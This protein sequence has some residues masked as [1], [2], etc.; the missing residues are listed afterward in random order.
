MTDWQFFARLRHLIHHDPMG[1]GLDRIAGRSLISATAPDLEAACRSLAQPRQLQVAIVTGFYVP[2][3]ECYETD[4][5]LGAI[6]LAETLHRLGAG[7]TIIA[8]PGCNAVH[9]VALR[10]NGLEDHVLL[11]DLPTPDSMHLESWVHRFW[12]QHPHLTHLVA[13]ERAG[14]SHHLQSL[15]HQY[16]ETP[17]PLGSF[18]R[19]VDA[20]SW[21][22]PHNM[23][24]H[25][26]GAFTSGAHR[27]FETLPAQVKSVG[28]GDGGNEIGMGRVPWDVVRNNIHLG[29]KIACRV[30][31][32]QLIVAGTSN[33]GAYALAAGV[34]WL[35]Q[36]YE[37]AGQF[38]ADREAQLWEATL[39]KEPLVDGVTAA[40]QLTVDG[41]EWKEYR[42]PMDAMQQLLNQQRSV[43]HGVQ[44]F[45]SVHG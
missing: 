17:A 19:E 15:G 1:R 42:Q 18:V 13:L 12:G 34:V 7:V 36:Q 23:R 44:R 38:D 26:I 24:G 16:G 39:A 5:P 14:P 6:F 37:L 9:E 31:T 20:I 40:C 10:L 21:N 28:I 29:A 45:P 22:R 41:L 3:A 2:Q 30:P 43:D 35:K 32:H 33:W 11:A 27:L 8:E 4:G 25:D